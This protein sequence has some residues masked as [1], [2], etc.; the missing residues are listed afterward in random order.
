M[1]SR[2]ELRLS[3]LCCEAI[4]VVARL[5]GEA[6]VTV[7]ARNIRTRVVGVT[8]FGTEDVYHVFMLL[9]EYEVLQSR[10]GGAR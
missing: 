10:V 4:V 9:Q 5:T 7:G 3:S 6:A 8:K 2:I 1:T